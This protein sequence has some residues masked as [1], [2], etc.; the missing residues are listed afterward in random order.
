[1]DRRMNLA[2][3]AKPVLPAVT[4][5]S[6]VSPLPSCPNSAEPVVY[7]CPV[8]DSKAEMF[9][10]HDAYNMKRTQVSKK[11]NKYTK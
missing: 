5:Y 2:Q 9:S 6:P 10:P 7:K 4:I 11:F 3:L 8:D 1:M